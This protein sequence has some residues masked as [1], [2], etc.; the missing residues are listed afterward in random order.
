ME[1]IFNSKEYL[2]QR[3]GTYENWI[4]RIQY[5]MYMKS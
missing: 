5:L 3:F 2:M 4:Q 1:E